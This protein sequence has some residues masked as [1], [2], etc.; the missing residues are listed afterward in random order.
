MLKYSAFLFLLVS[1]TACGPRISTAKQDGVN[2]SRFNTFAYLPNT[3]I[4]VPKK[5]YGDE[6]VNTLVIKTINANLQDAGYT[7]NTNN[8]DLLVLVSTKIDFDNATTANPVYASYPYVSGVSTV[9]P[10]YSNY[11][12]TGFASYGDIAGYDTDSYSYKEGT[13]IVNLVNRKTK[14]S[15]WKGA[16]SESLYNENQADA[17]AQLVNEIFQKYPL[18][19]KSKK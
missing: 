1:F 11:Y 12:Y 4:E 10:Y 7:I 5:N 8:P 3:D 18:V 13:V 16:T 17:I 15:V 14:E 9:S 2:L 19:E 6:D